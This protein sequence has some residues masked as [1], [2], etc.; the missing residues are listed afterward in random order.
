M[1]AARAIF[2]DGPNHSRSLIL[3]ALGLLGFAVAL[4]CFINALGLLD[5]P[6]M[7]QVAAPIGQP[8]T[9]PAPGR[10]QPS[11]PP[12][13]GDVPAL[14][15]SVWTVLAHARLE[16]HALNPDGSDDIQAEGI[17]FRVSQEAQ[18]A[19]TPASAAEAQQILALCHT[20]LGDQ[21]K[22]NDALLAE[23]SLSEP[24]GGRELSAWRLLRLVREKMRQGDRFMALTHM[25]EFLQ[26]Y[27]GTQAEEQGIRLAAQ[28]HGEMN[29]H[30]AA[31]EA[32]ALYLA[33][34]PAGPKR[35][36]VYRCLASAQGNTGRRDLAAQTMAKWDAERLSLPPSAP[37]SASLPAATPTP[38]AVPCSACGQ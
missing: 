8:S 16:F 19:P 7:R 13:S 30:A 11:V 36:F 23:L 6:S 33:K 37:A 20:Y 31:M 18:R 28:L 26:R 38:P 22:A 17:A 21:Q 10:P 9:A 29:N 4:A 35:E 15:D 27:P 24:K 1:I 2:G 5:E 34:F 14:T 3:Q 12:P 32:F 25:D